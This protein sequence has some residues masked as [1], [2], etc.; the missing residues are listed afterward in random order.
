[1]NYVTL[2][3]KEFLI[4]DSFIKE[5]ELIDILDIENKKIKIE[6][7]TYDAYINLKDF[8][9]DKLN[10]EIGIDS[11]YRSFEKQQEIYD[12]FLTKYGKSYTEKVVALPKT[13]EH[14]TGLAIDISIKKNNKFLNENKDLEKEEETFKKIHKYLYNFGFILRYPKNKENITGYQYEPWHIRY[15]GKIVAKIIYDNN[16]TLE[17]YLTNFSGVLLVNKEKEMTS[18]DVV[19]KVSHLLGIK[20]VGHTG[21]LDPIASGVLVLTIGRATKLGEILTATNKEYIAQVEIGKYTDTLDTTGI[22]IKEKQSH[23]KIDLESLIKSYQKTYLQEVPI[24]SAVKVNGKKLYEYARNNEKVKLPKKEVTI[25]EI[26]LLKTNDNSFSFRCLVS[27]GTYIRS[28]IR[29]MGQ[30][31]DEYFCMSDLIRTKQGKFSLKDAYSLDEIESNKFH[32]LS[33]K[34]DL[35]DYPTIVVDDKL[36]KNIING[37]PIKNIYNIKDKVLFED[38]NHKLLAIYQKDNTNLKIYKMLI[39]QM[40]YN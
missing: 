21:T 25:K 29:D 20:K 32:I 27:K 2:V 1:M 17:E 19:H 33:L 14:H 3:N 6:K 24:Y 31:I 13:S 15:V 16:L 11:A 12:D 9:K 30:S 36:K 10:I 18:F 35:Q 8:I 26:E 28:L 34:E 23:K 4:K 40:N 39:Q 7:N 38:K 5:V 37:R 22:I